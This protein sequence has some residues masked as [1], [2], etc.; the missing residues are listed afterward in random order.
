MQD[1][2]TLFTSL[3]THLTRIIFIAVTDN[4]KIIQP[5]TANRP[6]PKINQTLPEGVPPPETPLPPSIEYPPGVTPPPPPP[7]PYPYPT[8]YPPHRPGVHPARKPATGI[9]LKTLPIV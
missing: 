1:L 3:S 6:T 5:N 9:V 8:P 4:D 2:S 7:Y